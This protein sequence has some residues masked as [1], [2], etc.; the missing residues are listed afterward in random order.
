MKQALCDDECRAAASQLEKAVLDQARSNTGYKAQIIARRKEIESDTHC[1]SLHTSFQAQKAVEVAEIASK[2]ATSSGFVKA[3]ELLASAP[4]MNDSDD[5]PEVKVEARVQKNHFFAVFYNFTA[6]NIFIPQT[7]KKVVKKE[8]STKDKLKKLRKPKTKESTLSKSEQSLLDK[9]LTKIDAPS[10][11]S[12]KPEPKT[13]PKIEVSSEVKTEP[14]VKTEN[15]VNKQSEVLVENTA[16]NV[17]V[18][19]RRPFINPLLKSGVDK[20]RLDRL[21]RLKRANED[22]EAPPSKK[23]NL[24]K[25]V[26]FE[27]EEKNEV[28]KTAMKKPEYSNKEYTAND[29][30][31]AKDLVLKILSPYFTAG[32]FKA[33]CRK[34]LN[35]FE[36]EHFRPLPQEKP[37]FKE[38]AKMLTKSLF[39]VMLYMGISA[40]IN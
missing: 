15:E 21:K 5:E 24:S 10:I 18:K 9:Y 14:E 33:Q 25:S 11:P 35:F 8:L 40:G 6:E 39:E 1:S 12:S 4:I 23:P 13:S 3:S 34:F 2:Q 37:L 28:T 7:V 17:Q 29:L 32:R 30:N 22:S 20:S 31:S 38:M 36:T 26:K 27:V 19:K 16:E